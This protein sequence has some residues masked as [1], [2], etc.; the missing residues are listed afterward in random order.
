MLFHEHYES[1]AGYGIAHSLTGLIVT[2]RKILSL[3]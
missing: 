1:S 2:L 3:L